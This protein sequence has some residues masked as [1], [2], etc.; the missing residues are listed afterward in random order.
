[1]RKYLL[2][3][4]CFIAVAGPAAAETTISTAVNGPV[5]TSTVKQGAADDILINSSG[6]VNG[7]AGGGVIIDS[8]HKLK[9]QGS[10][11]IGN[12]SNVVGVDVAAGVTSGLTIDGKIAVDEPFTPSDADNDGDLDGPFATGSNRIGIR[13]NGGF[14]GNIVI[15]ST[16]AITVE[17]NNSA[18]ILLGGLVTGNF[19]HDGKTT[20]LGDNSIGIQLSGVN[21]SVRLA[22]E[23]SAQG[24]NN[25]AVRSTG[26]V[27]GSMTIQGKIASTGYRYT[28]PPADPSKL[29]A[30]DLLQGGPAVSIEGSVGQGIILAIPPKDNSTTD[31]DEDD[32]GIDDSKEGAASVLS[33]G[34]APAMRIGSAGNIVIGA[35]QGTGTGFGLIVD[36]AIAGDG[37]YTGVAGNGLQIG[38]MGGT[39]SIA[40]GIGVGAGGIIQAKSL[41]RAATAVRLGAGVSTAQ[42]QNSGK[43]LATS[44]NT[45]QSV[46]TAIDIAT[47]ASLPV[48]K[49][50]GTIGA[51]TGTDGTAIA[52]IDRSGSLSL[53]EN[54]GTISGNGA[55]TDSTRNVAIDLRSNTAGAT[56]KQTAVAASF[57]A[58]VIAGDILLGSGSDTLDV[59]DGK[60]TG[61]MSFGG[62]NNR[63][64]LYGDAV[65]AGK[66]SFGAGA[67]TVTADGTSIFNGTVDFGGG[68]DTLTIGGTSSFV[69]QLSNSSALVVSVD[70]GTFGV[71][72]SASIASLNVSNGG[73]LA[74]TLDKT[75]GA[76]SMLNVSGTATFG[77]GSTL[78]LSVANVDQ[79]EGHFVVLNAG[80][81]VGGSNL[82]ATP[83]LLPFLYKGSL[84]VT[85]NQV[86]VDIARKSTTELGL[87]RSESAAFDAIYAALANDDEIGDSFL[88]IRAQDAFVGQIRQMLPE[89]AGGTFEAVTMGDRAVARMLNDP[90]PP[91][92]Q[93]EGM[94]YW[95][96]QVAW[97]SSK[98][99]GD[100]AGYKIG[101]WGASGGA[102]IS[103]KFGK[104]GGSLAYLW[105]KDD[106]K[107]TDNRLTADQYSLAAHWRFATDGFQVA[108][109]GSY[110]FLNFN[111]KR[112][113]SST[114][115]GEPIEREIEGNW[116]GNLLSASAVASQ[117]LWSGGFF[118]RPSAGIEYYSLS[119]DG[120]QEKGG[121][122]AL[123]L[124]VDKRKSD[125]FA[126][127]GLLIAGFEMGALD[128][129]EGYFRFEAE[130]GRR[131]IVGGSL[132]KTSARFTD[133]ETFVLTPEERQSGWIGRLR[134]ISGDSSFR[135]AGEVGAEER[136]DKMGFSARATVS[137]GL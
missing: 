100:T 67:D 52:I 80:T 114:V 22:G 19:T 58:P 131:Q 57:A 96:S 54:S 18:G 27:S 15:G 137:L 7:T 70:K 108:A 51:T 28:S 77:T 87:N 1:M 102:E 13:T 74:V 40:N 73:A 35:T 49:N 134:A 41:D 42:L 123:D 84:S 110:A 32:D 43:I 48:L 3:S 127:T 89:H 72:K 25:V 66:L 115:G 11:L 20:V 78:K 33:Y 90:K 37:V 24:Q 75:A 46:A 60:V 116:N 31:N 98:S 16:G 47:G 44:G 36:G 133:G 83:D 119:E 6:V 111:G 71:L 53:I 130:A 93:E 69:A 99:I 29:D 81:L 106:D 63:F 101:G 129:D 113:F 91:Y 104:F 121:G 103:T 85:G 64:A 95:A 9:N 125:E 14:T 38:G 117:D 112:F 8:N 136:E 135:V 39:V 55:A 92:K 59:A 5:R 65:A 79:A 122:E 12:L 132:G 105:G 128:Q 62:G 68:A 26:N 97:G 107:A 126:V 120:Y 86:A 17:G 21:G 50:S 61:T 2:A 23:V 45:A 88:E 118:V 124:T 82:T 34:A 56:I 94:S 4:T 30:D 76:S 109:R 10:I